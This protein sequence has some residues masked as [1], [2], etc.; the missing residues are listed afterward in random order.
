MRILGVV[1]K[2]RFVGQVLNLNTTSAP[3]T[4]ATGRHTVTTNSGVTV[5]SG[6]ANFITGNQGIVCLPDGTTDFNASEMGDFD[7][8]LKFRLTADDGLGMLFVFTNNTLATPALYSYVSASGVVV[9]TG[10]G[11]IYH[12]TTIVVGGSENT[13]LLTRREMTYTLTV[14][15]VS[16]SL[17]ANLK[18]GSLSNPTL[19]IGAFPIASPSW[20]FVGTIR[21]FILDIV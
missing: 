11:T 21:D 5:V 9:N 13:Y 20:D 3:I 14:N 1:K 10:G 17:V 8:Q 19:L 18:P 6:K 12:P 16:A 15:G 2:P 7:L 4:D